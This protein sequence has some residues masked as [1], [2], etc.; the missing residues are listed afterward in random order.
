MMPRVLDNSWHSLRIFLLMLLRP[1]SL[2]AQINALPWYQTTLQQWATTALGNAPATVLEAG[3]ATGELARF[4]AEHGYRVTGVDASPAMQARANSRNSSGAHFMQG[5]VMNLPFTEGQF[6]HV[7]AASLLNVLE[8]PVSA[9][10]EMMRVCKP[11]GSVSVL[12]PQ[13]GMSTENV[14]H[15]ADELQVTGFSR[16]ALLAWHRMARKL[17]IA[18]LEGYF[19]EAGFSSTKNRQFLNSMVITVTGKRDL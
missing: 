9:L 13:A 7:I 12:V 18:T 11:G 19:N 6:D 2:F 1:A 16:A 15:L 5:S 17:R 14:L 4:L 8:D 10:R 3:C